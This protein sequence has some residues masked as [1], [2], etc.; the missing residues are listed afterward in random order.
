MTSTDA[1]VVIQWMKAY[2]KR[3]SSK[4]ETLAGMAE[5]GIDSM[6]A[7]ACVNGTADDYKAAL[8]LLNEA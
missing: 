6:L 7:D 3:E 5:D 1:I 2:L 8:D 4:K